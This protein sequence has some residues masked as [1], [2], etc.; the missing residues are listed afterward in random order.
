MSTTKERLPRIAG[1]DWRIKRPDAIAVYNAGYHEN[2]GRIQIGEKPWT[3]IGTNGKG[4]PIWDTFN[5]HAEALTYAFK[6]ASK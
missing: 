6:A 3:I 4:E 1:F 5:T 2:G